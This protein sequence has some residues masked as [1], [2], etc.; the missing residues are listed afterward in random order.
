MILEANKTVDKV[1]RETIKK[2]PCDQSFNL[3]GFVL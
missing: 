3:D 2:E 1:L